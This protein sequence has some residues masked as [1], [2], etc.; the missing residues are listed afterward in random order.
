MT[1][2]LRRSLVIERLHDQNHAYVGGFSIPVEAGRR[3]LIRAMIKAPMRQ[4]SVTIGFGN[5]GQPIRSPLAAT[6]LSDATLFMYNEMLM[7]N[8]DAI[9]EKDRFHPVE[10][11]VT[12]PENA[13]EMNIGFNYNYASGKAYFD[14]LEVFKLPM[15]GEN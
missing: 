1:R 2:L 11:V 13:K 6:V 10:A 4:P 7:L 8:T 9:K 15:P 14:N 12:A 5:A 3:Y